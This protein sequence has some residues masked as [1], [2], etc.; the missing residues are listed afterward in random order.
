[1]RTHRTHMAET[2]PGDD[3]AS[4]MSDAAPPHRHHHEQQQQQPHL[5]ERAEEP[6]THAGLPSHTGSRLLPPGGRRQ[7][8]WTTALGLELAFMVLNLVFVFSRLLVWKRARRKAAKAER[9]REARARSSAATAWSSIDLPTGAKSSKLETVQGLL[10]GWA[11][12]LLR[13]VTWVCAFCTSCAW[14]CANSGF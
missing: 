2:P 3:E 7:V 4:A 14:C 13:S 1:M 5:S 8:E 10:C 12:Y 11:W 6:T 9:E